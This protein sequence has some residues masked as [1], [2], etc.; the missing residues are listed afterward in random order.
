MAGDRPGGVVKIRTSS[1]GAV[2]RL[3]AWDASFLPV[4]SDVTVAPDGVAIGLGAPGVELARVC[5]W[6]RGQ[7]ASVALQTLA[8]AAFLFE[9]GWYPSRA[10]LRTARVVRGEAGVWLRL[11]RLP[12]RR[13]EDATLERRLRVALGPADDVLAA[14]VGPLLR[15]L[16]PER[17]AELDRAAASRPAWEVAEA[18]VEVLL[19]EGRGS[20]VL[21]HPAGAGR[22]LWARHFALPQTGVFWLEE[23]PLLPALTVAGQLAAAGRGVAFA[24]GAFEEHDVARLLA[25]AAADGRD[26]LVLTTLSL[27]GVAALPLAGSAD[28]VWVLARHGGLS[29]AHATA[30][31]EAGVQQPNLARLMLEASATHGF[32]RPPHAAPVR[33]REALASPGARRAL[34]WLE[35]A[36]VGLGQADLEALAGTSSEALEEL[37]RLGLARMRHGAWHSVRVAERPSREKLEVMADA[38]PEDTPQGVVARALAMGQGERAAAWCEARLASGLADEALAVARAVAVCP[39]VRLAGAEAALNLGRLAEA[40]DL[41]E[42][43]AR[44]ERGARWHGLAAW[45][46]EQAGVTE[47]AAAELAA[48][49]G[50][51]PA[52]LSARL[53][54]VAAELARRSGDHEEEHRHLERAVA[55][56]EPPLPDTELALAAW[57]GWTALRTLRRARAAVWGGDEKARVLQL[58]GLAALDRESCAAAATGLRAALRTA[59]GQNLR[60]LGE[61]H[62]DLGCTAILSEQGAVADRHLML[63]EGLLERCGSRRTVTLVRANRA[64]L[65]CD[66]LDWRT[67]RELTVAARDTRGALDDATTWLGEMELARAELARGDVAAVQALLPRLDEGV[68]RHDDHATLVQSLAALKAHLA[69]ARG[70]LRGALATA[71]GAEAGERELI[72]TLGRAAEGVDPP[73]GLTQRWGVAVTAQ[74]LA[75]WHRGDEAAARARL[76]SAFERTPREAAVG[77]AR[78]AALLAH[79]GQHLPTEWAEFERVA[80]AALASGELEGW[81]AI[82]RGACGLDPVRLVR[83]LDGIVNAGTDALAAARLEALARAL[84]LRWLEISRAGAPLGSWGTAEGEPV[85]LDA[86]GIRVRAAGAMHSVVEATLGL[87]ARHLATRPEDGGAE[88]GRP[89]GELL[90]KSAAFEAVREQIARWSPLPLTVLVVGEPGTGKEL[91]ARELHRESRRSGPFVPVNCAGIPA[92]LLEAELFGVVRGAYTGAD[93]DRPGLVEAAEGGTLF[94][95]EVGELPPE[96]QGKLLRLLQGSEVRRVGATRSRTVDVRFIAATNRDLQAATAA[97][98]FRQDL[99]YRVAV[100]VIEVPPLRER[101]EDIDVLARHFTARSASTLKRP[102]VCL[103]P[104]AVELLRHGSWPGNV[105]E[106]EIVII[107]AVAAARPGEVLGPDRFPGV[108]A[109]APAD[110]HLGAWSDALAEF[111]RGYFTAVLR[112]SGGNRTRAARRAGVSRQTLLYHLRE[113]GIRGGN[114]G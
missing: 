2:A 87:V 83:A 12:R 25:R 22:A 11:T 4:A 71:C 113:L 84:D 53:E 43:V 100:A 40:E 55:A 103:A 79:R 21:R 99:Y 72:L 62:A 65:A 93:R 85:E 52:R 27:P 89:D 13:L 42:G 74:L 3:L 6:P 8:A 90:G 46:A 30:A 101:V 36:P 97:G 69:L 64:V 44:G 10:V 68:R 14:V 54:L 67:C 70:D 15:T 29:R 61:I 66:R 7:R 88:I 109:S 95:D 39:G 59:S 49:T 45:W 19:R 110:R 9:R 77:L 18:W 60:L 92:S 32:S 94:L 48:T 17:I 47:R 23:E 50:T 31:M 105:R 107:R 5:Q 111:R 57:S 106:L 63:A 16:L 91:V 75:A 56:T 1:A 104:A 82:L 20:T 38:L 28:A 37:D 26:S 41:L 73:I 33:E 96:L 114:P 102:G 81:A 78:F 108:V 112:E 51:L 76:L 58:L 34:A 86:D 24:S 80:E 98:A 35:S